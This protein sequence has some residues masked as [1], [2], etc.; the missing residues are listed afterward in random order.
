MRIITPESEHGIVFRSDNPIFG[1]NGW[2]SV[3]R[4]ENNVLYAVASGM[5]VQHVDPFGKTIMCV[6]RDEGKT[7]TRPMVIN[8]T[9]LDDRDAGILYMG[10]GRMLV[11]WFCHPAEIYHKRYANGMKNEASVTAVG[12][13][14][15]LMSCYPYFNEEQGKGGSF[16]CI[17]EDYGVTWSDIIRI[18]V[19]APHGPNICRDGS[20]VYVG[21]DMYINN[22]DMNKTGH[23]RSYKSTDGGYTWKETAILPIPEG[24][25]NKNFHEP[26]AI[27]LPDGK[28]LAVVRA[29]SNVDDTV[30]LI[31][32]G[33]FEHN[34]KYYDGYTMY[35]S[36]SSDGGYTWS[37][38]SPTGISG[39]PGQLMLHSS[40]AL[41]C[42]YGC[43]EKPFSE[44]AAV[45]YDMGKTWSE[46]YIIDDR[47]ID[48]DHGYPASVEM[49]DGSIVTVYYQKYPGD[50]KPSILYSRWKLSQ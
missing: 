24:T 28:L 43:R 29:Q 9:A 42:S 26:H 2:P 37:V 12:A 16:I 47:C 46:D 15:G 8:D 27:E 39:S 21:K 48:N 35:T 49:D 11:T 22:V 5:R 14:M 1:Y 40:G 36:E 41:V 34:G 33:G 10:S 32:D 19:S 13:V 38:L 45:S 25:V 6:S 4:D 44:R 20:L 18:P 30:K 17:S 31:H 23:I 50:R 3:C 7:W